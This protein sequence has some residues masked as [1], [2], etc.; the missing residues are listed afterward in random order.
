MKE[1]DHAK[2]RIYACRN[3]HCGNYEISI[4]AMKFIENDYA[5]KTRATSS[6]NR[7]VGTDNILGIF[8]EGGN[9]KFSFEMRT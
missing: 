5:L 3:R 9:V 8:M 1:T 6:A 2:R 4:E 7:C